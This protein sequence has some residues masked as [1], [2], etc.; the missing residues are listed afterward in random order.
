MNVV[1]LAHRDPRHPRA[2][3]V[4]TCIEEIGSRLVDRGHAVTL[5]C[6]RFIDL[7]KNESYRGINILRV[8]VN[9]FW[10]HLAYPFLSTSKKKDTVFIDDLGHVVPWLSPQ[11]AKSPSVAFFH[12]LHARTLS[13][14]VSPALRLP[15]I[16][17]EKTY[18]IIYRK[19]RFVTTSI[20]SMM[21]L[22]S[23]GIRQE[24]I[25]RIPLGV[26][27]DFFTPTAKFEE[28]TV[29]YFGGF[30]N[31]KRADIALK[32]FE[33]LMKRL[34][35]AKML[36]IGTGPTMQFVQSLVEGS[37]ARHAISFLGRVP[38]TKLAQLI[39]GSWVNVHTAVH[40]GWGL[41]ILEASASGTPTVAFDV[42]GVRQVVL[43]NVNGLTVGDGDVNSL[44]EAMISVINRTRQ[45]SPSCRSWSLKYSWDRCAAKWAVLLQ[46]TLP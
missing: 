42:P 26:D 8:G 31:Y 41:S 25:T 27:S 15:L 16:A 13:G 3:G 40:E 17:L 2:G 38:R 9:P 19:T 11:L 18:P 1:W 20:D 21:D 33:L 43:D 5:V 24:S 6:P 36:L 28:P 46:N 34:P 14:Q 39:A 30:R 10:A 4:E 7:P 37:P 32:A 22:Q 44:S 35:N 23:L 12:H 29:V 45:L